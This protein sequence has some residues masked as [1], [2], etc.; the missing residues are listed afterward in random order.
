VVELRPVDAEAFAELCDDLR[1]ADQRELDAAYAR[2]AREIIAESIARSIEPLAAWDDDRLVA[3]FGHA[4]LG[5][6]LTPMASPWLL[7]TPLLARH[8]GVLVRLSRQYV[9]AWRE[10]HPLLV[11]FVDVR[12]V[13]SI[14][15]LKA[16]GFTLDEPAPFG[17]MGLPFHRFHKGYN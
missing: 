16:V 13:A 17:V 5:P 3:I 12:N 9:A 15:Y 7:G 10:Q 2:P 1:P 8:A 11:N 6:I 14:R 4:P